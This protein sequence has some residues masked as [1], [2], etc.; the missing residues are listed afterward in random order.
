MKKTDQSFDSFQLEDLFELKR[1]EKPQAEFWDDFDA[2]LQQR[3]LNSA[4]DR[5]N[6]FQRSWDMLSAKMLP[7][8]A[9]ATAAAAVAFSFAPAFHQATNTQ[10]VDNTPVASVAVENVL[11][12][13]VE[14]VDFHNETLSA[15]ASSDS[16]SQNFA[17]TDISYE[18]QGSEAYETNALV[19]SANAQNLK[20]EEQLF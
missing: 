7:V 6:I 2:Q 9:F 14:A 4:I 19:V 13:S 10:P 15:T 1:N 16:A 5:R 20:F 8:S 11:S 18:L 12:V 3:I 17:I